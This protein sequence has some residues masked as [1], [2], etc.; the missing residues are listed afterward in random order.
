MLDSRFRIEPLEAHHNRRQFS[1][2][3][4][5][6]DRYFTS[7]ASQDVR[8]YVAA[9]L[10]L[11][12]TD[13]ERVAGFYT[14]SSFTVQSGDLP[15]SASRKLPRY[16]LIPTVLLGRLAVDLSYQRRGLGGHLLNDALRRALRQSPH[17]GSWA[18]IV[19]AKD[20]QARAFYEQY[21]F[22]RFTDEQHR[23]FLP[24]Q[25]IARLFPDVLG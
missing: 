2:G 12:D 1:C 7:Q 8:R 13:E 25:T 19:D 17:I 20:D 9:V 5:A 10:V 23:L 18:V 4:D 22:V 14:L 24:M 6:L 16:P 21:G 11:V 3:A 15:L